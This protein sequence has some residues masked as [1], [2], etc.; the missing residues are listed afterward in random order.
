MAPMPFPIPTWRCF[1]S[2]PSD[3]EATTVSA[4]CIFSLSTLEVTWFPGTKSF[5]LI[6]QEKAKVWRWAILGIEGIILGEGRQPSQE[7]A[8]RIAVESLRV[9]PA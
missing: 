5:A 9:V 4:C 6:E 7:E 1:C 8:K 3:F 2:L